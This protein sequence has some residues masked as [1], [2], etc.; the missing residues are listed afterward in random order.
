MY[1]TKASYKTLESRKSVGKLENGIKVGKHVQNLQI[2]THSSTQ[3]DFLLKYIFSNVA[4]TQFAAKLPA[5]QNAVYVAISTAGGQATTVGELNQGTSSL[6]TY[7][8]I[9]QNTTLQNHL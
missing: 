4:E 9:R 3:A 5:Q 6:Q 8:S 7:F 1:T 2:H